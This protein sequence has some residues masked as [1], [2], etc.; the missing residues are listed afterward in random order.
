MD[1]YEIEFMVNGKRLV[2]LNANFGGIPLLGK[3]MHQNQIQLV[4]DKSNLIS[5][6]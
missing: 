4:T 1:K 5:F 6:L 3:T 2:Q